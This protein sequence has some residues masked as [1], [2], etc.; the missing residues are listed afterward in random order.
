MHR[1]TETSILI[2]KYLVWAIVLSLSLLLPLNLSATERQYGS[3][4]SSLGI[5]DQQFKDKVK[6]YLNI[7]YKL[8]GTSKNGM[9]CSGFSKTIYS[10]FFGIEL[11][12]RSVDQ[13]RST[14]LRKIDTRKLQPGD[15]IF[16]MNP[17]RKRVNHVGVYISDRHFIHASLSKG[18]TVAS[19]DSNYWKRRFVGSK[20]HA[21]LYTTPTNKILKIRNIQKKRFH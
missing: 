16:F 12:R 20:R 7:P 11:P 14:E 8:G 15:L 17:K 13:F 4:L 1:Q 6:E 2:K 9:D 10:K 18:I 3:S 21:S 19:L 5:S